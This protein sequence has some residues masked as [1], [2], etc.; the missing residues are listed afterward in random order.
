MGRRFNGF[1]AGYIS[2]LGFL[3]CLIRHIETGGC[4][5]L[6][7]SSRFVNP[8][9]HGPGDFSRCPDGFITGSS[10]SLGFSDCL[11]RSMEGISGRLLGLPAH[12]LGLS[13]RLHGRSLGHF[14][15]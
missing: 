4:R 3:A 14:S 9:S 1:V 8:V 5:C 2:L 6:S 12:L 10:R 11:F 13:G 15:D 7:F